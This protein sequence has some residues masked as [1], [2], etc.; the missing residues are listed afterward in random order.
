MSTLSLSDI[1]Q[2]SVTISPAAA[3]GPSF[4]LGLIVGQ[5]TVIAGTP[6]D[7]VRLYSSTA[8][9]L[10]DGFSN[11]SPEYLAAQLYFSQTPQPAQVLIGRWNQ[12]VE[13]ALA[14]VQ[15]CRAANPNWY[16]CTVCG[17]SDQDI[18]MI[19]GYVNSMSP[20]GVQFATVADAAVLAATPLTAGYETGG[21][22]PATSLTSSESTLQIAVDADVYGLTPT[23]H[24]I[25]LSNPASLVTGAEIATALQAAVQALGNQYAAV[26]VQ[27]TGGVYVVTSGSKGPLSRVRIADGASNDMA[28]VLKLGAANGAVDTDG[29]GSVGLALQQLQYMRTLTQYSTQ[30]PNAAAGAMG[31]AM[32]ANTGAANSSFCLANKVI[33][34]VAPETLTETQASGLVAQNVNFVATYGN[35]YQLFQNGAMASGMWFDEILGLDQ[36]VSQITYAVMNLLVANNKIPQTEGGMTM[37]RQAIK[38]PCQKAVST[39]FLAAGLWEGPPLTVGSKTLNTGDTLSDGYLVLSDLIANQSS[40]DRAARKSPPVY[41]IP[42]LAGA[43]QNVVI[44]VY[45]QQ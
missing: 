29:T 15:A 21:A 45:V 20:A 5:S 2:I 42:S 14:A 4:N 32:G 30:T 44:A 36:M 16:V 26:T 12:A 10:S 23:Y 25:T 1:V 43:I 27:Y 3:V 37:L 38:G 9:M 11:T 19:A 28:A 24:S 31:Y 39:G 40:G 18:L 13:T 34:G 22:T 17:A 41:V 6:Q 33:A 8:G 7:R 35:A